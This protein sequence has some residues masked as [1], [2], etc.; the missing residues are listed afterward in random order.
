MKKETFYQILLTRTP[1]ELNEF[2]SKKGTKKLVNAITFL[3]DETIEN[4][5]INNDMV[6]DI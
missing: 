6:N 3:D 2:I 1:E 4:M 5:K